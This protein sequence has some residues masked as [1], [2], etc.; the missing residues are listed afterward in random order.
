MRRGLVSGLCLTVS[1]AIMLSGCT[2]TKSKDGGDKS[3]EASSAKV[4]PAGQFPITNEKT[5]LKVLVKSPPFVENFA[6]NELTKY[7]EEKTN[8]HIE[9]EVADEKAAAEKLN[10]VLGSGDY[11]D[12]IM[13]FGVSNTQQ[14]IYGNQGVFLP[15][16]KLIEQY[17][18]ETKKMF[19]AA[20]YAKDMITAPDGNIYALPQINECFHCTYSQKAWIYKPWLDKL[21]LKMPTTTDEFYEVLK[22]FKTR[23]PNGNNKAD[24]IPLVGAAV[25]P[26]V[27]IDQFLMNAF[28]LNPVEG[29]APQPEK[30]LYLNNGKVTVP[31]NKPE[32]KEGLQYLRKL[33]AEGLISPQSFTQDRNQARQ[34]GE[35][36]DN[37]IA[38]VVVAQHN[39]VFTEFYGKSGRWLDYVTVPPLKGPKGVQVTPYRA[40]VG[41]GQY[42]ITK[43]SKYPEAAFRLADLMYT[44]EWALRMEIGRPDKEW[45]WADKSEVGINGKPAIWKRLANLPPVQNVTWSQTGPSLRTNDFRLGLVADP[46][47]PQEIILYNETK[48]NYEPYKQD[49]ATFLPQLFFTNDQA[50]ELADLEKT[51]TDHVKEMIARFVTGDA[52]LDKDWDSYL[53]NLDNMNLKRYLEIYQAAYDAKNK[54]K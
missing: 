46:N 27:G 31:F 24:E 44:Q 43:A 8:V 22:A 23:D 38:G 14:L 49:P 19:E 21:G 47:N 36:P 35:N 4:T 25:G 11:P 48:K 2:D 42:L 54:K 1:A 40:S 28:T 5:T 17:G 6:T 41:G 33:Y 52:N 34:M 29:S 10:L 32:W 51:I 12:V 37:V 15:L 39:G 7:L 30:R 9:W 3:S 16:N 13:G 18:T 53:K 50:A 20:P 26:A 45:K